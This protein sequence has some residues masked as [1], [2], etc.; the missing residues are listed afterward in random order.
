MILERFNN[1]VWIVFLFSG[2]GLAQTTKLISFQVISPEKKGIPFVSIFNQSGK[3][4]ITSDSSGKFSLAHPEFTELVIEV[5]HPE[6]EKKKF[7]IKPQQFSELVFLQ[8]NKSN[9]EL[10]EVVVSANLY[11]IKKSES[12]IAVE[13][14]S[15]KLF[16]KNPVP[17]LFEAVGMINGVRPQSNCNICNTGDIHLNGME[18]PYTMILID[19]MPIV[20][21]L[22]SVYGLMGIPTG[23]IDRV[24]ITKGPASSLYGSEAMGGVINV[25]TKNTANAPKLKVELN[26]TSWL[27]SN[28]DASLKQKSKNGKFEILHGINSYFYN[29]PIDKNSDGFT[30]LTQQ[31]RISVFEKFRIG[32]EDNKPLEMATRLVMEDR[33]G[34]QTTW[35]KKFR[36]GDSIYGESIITNRFE[37]MGKKQWQTNLPLF[38]QGSYCYHRQDSY[39]GTTPLMAEQH[40]GFIQSYVHYRISDK[41]EIL[42]GA[43]IRSN[44]YN[45]NTIVTQKNENGFIRDN[46]DIRIIPGIFFQHE[47]KLNQ[48]KHLSGVRFDFD[49]NHG[50][51]VSPRFGTKI[52]MK[53]FGILRL[54][55]ASGYRVVNLF[56]EEH[57]ALTGSRE[58]IIKEKIKP[59]QSVNGTLNYEN[60]WNKSD[61]IFKSETSI[62]YYYFFNKIIPDYSNPNQIVY[63]NLNGYAYTWG[64][65]VSLHYRNSEFISSTIGATYSENFSVNET[66]K[67]TEQLKS[68]R[69]LLNSVISLTPVRN[70][71]SIDISSNH[72]GPMLLPIQYMDPRPEISPWIH[73]VNFQVT[74]K[75]RK[76]FDYYLGIKNLFNQL[77][78][79][80]ILRPNDP[81]DKNVNDSISN[82]YGHTFDTAYNYASMQGIRFFGGV[83]ITID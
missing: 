70:K 7:K 72:T 47:F 73:L 39:Y 77:P 38:T 46:P 59:E 65:S 25:I 19:G 50:L 28:L 60:K 31:K 10:E 83:R 16:Q 55:S 69:M 40:T 26:G 5:F 20:S 29:K 23:I 78:K 81:F 49:Q 71:L 62:F 66:G 18:G 6:F 42:S 48:V 17:N 24:E 12:P 1:I 79:N 11:E 15:S 74:W 64:T 27:E 21:G 30:D 34:G 82:P 13:V 63:Q 22:A 61:H 53:Q 32:R 75:S 80:P 51:V 76:N 4:G 45:D 2:I 35:N 43:A 14:I 33:W 41:H 56:T 8:L 36:G 54:N 57:A 58:I 68:P 9:L 3:T 67:K 52:D 44:F 37:W